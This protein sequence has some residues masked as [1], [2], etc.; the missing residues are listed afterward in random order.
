MRSQRKE[1]C[2]DPTWTTDAGGSPGPPLF[3]DHDPAL[4]VRHQRVLSTPP[5]TTRSTRCRAHSPISDVPDQ[6]KEGVDIHLRADDL[7]T[8]D[9]LYPRA[10]SE[11]RHRA[12]SV[13]AA[14]TEVT[15]DFEPRRS[16]GHAGGAER[17]A[18]SREA[19]DSLW[20]RPES[21]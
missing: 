5:E 19:G 15:A 14:R 4:P 1:F 13:S 16:Q 7:R 18:P 10:A 20:V 2:C 3:S 11:G 9:L 6:R 8:A 21:Q 12:H 17:F